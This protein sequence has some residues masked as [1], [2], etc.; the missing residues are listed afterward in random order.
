L[1]RHLKLIQLLNLNL[2][3]SL[4]SELLYEPYSPVDAAAEADKDDQDCD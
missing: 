4:S 1:H 3:V 2:L